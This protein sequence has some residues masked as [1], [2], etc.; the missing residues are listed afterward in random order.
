[1]TRA[2]DVVVIGGGIAGAVVCHE[3]AHRGVKVT[4]VEK[5]SICAGP[6]ARSCGIIRQHYSHEITADMAREAL[7]IFRAFDE[8]VGGECDFH[9]AGFLITAREDTVE[10]IVANVALQQ[11]IGI[12]TRMVT[13]EEI[14]DIEPHIDLEGIVAGAYEPASGYADP[15]ATT[16]SY[17]ARAEERGARI[18]TGT[19]VLAIRHEAGR[20]TGI[21]TDTGDI[22]AGAV[23]MAAGPWAKALL[24]PLGIALPTEIGRVQVGLF[25]RPESITTHGIFG[26]TCLGIY[27]RPEGEMMLVG[28]LETDDAELVVDDPD[29]YDHEMDFARIESY[30]ER[31]MRRYPEMSSGRFHNGYASLYDLTADWQPI[32][33]K[34]PGLEG[35]YG[36]VGSSG[37]GF[38]LAPILGRIV[39]QLVVGEPTNDAALEL[40][41]FDRFEQ[42]TRADGR[43]EGHKILG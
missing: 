32:V 4:L 12:E 15:Y 31:I 10:T 40:F 7:G 8:A 36:M 26:D 29:Y 22:A 25:D 41:A 14:R 17:V 35:L 11:S 20:V 23:V 16:H 3:L 18:L 27:A 21:E 34:L 2:S 37:H 24:A 38:K 1:V 6:T 42:G 43:Y 9:Q 13:P 33:G 19:R 28:S 5:D 39:A 30:S